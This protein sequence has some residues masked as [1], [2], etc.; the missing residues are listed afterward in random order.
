MVG[1]G[2]EGW[3]AV[4]SFMSGCVIGSLQRWMAGMSGWLGWIDGWDEWMV[5]MGGWLGWTD[6]WD[7]WMVGMDGWLG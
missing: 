2:L 1:R 7:G 3:N 5:G 6:G 4:G